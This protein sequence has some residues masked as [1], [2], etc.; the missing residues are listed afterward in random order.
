VLAKPKDPESV[1]KAKREKELKAVEE[2]QALLSDF[3]QR[4][5]D[6]DF[7]TDS[8]NTCWNSRRLIITKYLARCVPCRDL[9]TRQTLYKQEVHLT[10]AALAQNPKVYCVWD[11]RKWVLE[12]MPFPDWG[13]ELG[14]IEMLLN[15]DARNFHVW[16]YRPIHA[17]DKDSR[18][19]AAP[20]LPRVTTEGEMEFTR[21]K[22]SKDLGNYSAWHYR[23]KMF[24]KLVNESQWSLTSSERAKVV[25][26]EFELVLKV[27][28]TD[29]SIQSAWFYHRW[30]LGFAEEAGAVSFLP[31]L[32]REVKNVEE[33][34]EFEPDTRWC[35]DALV[36][37]RLKLADLQGLNTQETEGV[38][39]E[40]GELLTRLQEIDKDRKGR[41]ADLAKSSLLSASAS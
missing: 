13:K 37:C 1:A 26:T 14:Q 9:P 30:L 33:L 7:S 22:I 25:D 24:A 2:Y 18:P 8:L 31:V 10:T 16:D 23:T 27:L 32:K 19:L 34:Y 35:M 3:N 36:R 21:A 17:F 20:E 11:Y 40:C 15:A 12:N 41:Y 29:P 39:K 5:R 6:K 4:R 38:K 28:W